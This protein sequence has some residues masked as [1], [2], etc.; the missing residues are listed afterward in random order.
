MPDGSQP[1]DVPAK[2]QPPA[3]V[4]AAPKMEDDC[5]MMSVR[6]GPFTTPLECERELPK[7]LQGAV[8]EYAELSLGPEAAAVRL[9]DDDLQ[10][11]V[12]DALD[13]APAHGNRRQQPGHGLVARPGRFRRSPC[14]SGSRPRP[15]G[16]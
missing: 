12:R 7:A 5:Y 9:P 16:S 15:S 4:N 13:R 6:V 11:L 3:W 8:A 1:R 14:S 2:P 10:Q